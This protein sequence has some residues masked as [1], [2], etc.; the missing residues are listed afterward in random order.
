[1][2]PIQYGFLEKFPEP[3]DQVEVRCIRRQENQLLEQLEG[4]LGING[5]VIAD[6]VA[7]AVAIDDTIDVEPLLRIL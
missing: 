1:M 6:N 5:V 2:A 3:F 4:R 7:E